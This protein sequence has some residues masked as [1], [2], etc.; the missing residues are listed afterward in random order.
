MNDGAGETQIWA[1]WLASENGL[2]SISDR[3]KSLGDKGY[4]QR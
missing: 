3:K 4:C 1:L 2:V